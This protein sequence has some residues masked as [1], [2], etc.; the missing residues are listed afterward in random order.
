MSST[1]GRDV[2]ARADVKRS[3]TQTISGAVFIGVLKTVKS[4]VRRSEN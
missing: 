3:R 1:I 4:I 2:S